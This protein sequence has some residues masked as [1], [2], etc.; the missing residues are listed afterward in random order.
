M[1][2]YQG[3]I[4]DRAHMNMLQSAVDAVQGRARVRTICVEDIIDTCDSVQKK[5]NISQTALEGVQ[6]TVDRHA[7]KFPAAYNGRPESTIFQAVY[8]GRKWRLLKVYRGDVR[9]PGHGTSIVLTDVAKS[10]VLAAACEY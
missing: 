3:I 5:L 2:K 9:R 6:I 8:S 1:T 4:I 7:Q 10:A